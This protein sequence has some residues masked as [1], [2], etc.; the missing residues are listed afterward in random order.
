MGSVYYDT[1]KEHR[2]E[3]LLVVAEGISRLSIL[4]GCFQ[5]LGDGFD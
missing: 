2:G 3:N 4:R 5:S 1:L